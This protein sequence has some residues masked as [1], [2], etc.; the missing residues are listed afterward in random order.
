MKL[1]L[2]RISPERETKER[3]EELE[4]YVYRLVLELREILEKE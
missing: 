4:R 2:P 3:L 1:E